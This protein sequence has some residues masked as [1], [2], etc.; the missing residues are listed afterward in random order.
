MKIIPFPKR[1]LPMKV[2]TVALT[3][4]SSLD[5]IFWH[6]ETTSRM[7]ILFVDKSGEGI[8]YL[9]TNTWIEMV[10]SIIEVDQDIS[11]YFKIKAV[12][13]WTWF[14]S[15]AEQ[16]R[17]IGFHDWPEIKRQTKKLNRRGRYE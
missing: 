14:R 9:A 11:Y 3:R 5:D 2:M 4:D 10:A 7:R 6:L 12:P 13:T 8:D 16:K 1:P 17:T 15:G